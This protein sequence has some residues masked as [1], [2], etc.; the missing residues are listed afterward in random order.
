MPLRRLRAG[1][2]SRY[3]GVMEMDFELVGD[4]TDVESIAVNFSIRE[5][6][7]LKARYGGR[8]W[9][10]LK[11]VAVVRLPNGRMPCGIKKILEE[12]D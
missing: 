12:A 9:R 7:N 8:R 6:K 1:F 5:R 4:V 11:G 10:K 2:L 3:A